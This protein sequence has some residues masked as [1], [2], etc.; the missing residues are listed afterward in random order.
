M[1]KKKKLKAKKPTQLH[2]SPNPNYG[3]SD[4][5]PPFRR[6]HEASKPPPSQ[7]CPAPPPL[8]NP[9][10][11]RQKVFV[12][13]DSNGK[14]NPSKVDHYLQELQKKHGSNTIFEVEFIDSYTLP[15]TYRM[16]QER[17]H[18]DAIVVIA[19]GT[20]DIRL[21]K[22]SPDHR[23][24]KQNPQ[25]WVR[26]II[27]HLKAQTSNHNIRLVASP[28]STLFDIK[29]FN[30]FNFHLCRSEGVVFAYTLA[31]KEHL[32]RDGYHIS[33]MFSNVVAQTTAAS[34]FNVNPTLAFSISKQ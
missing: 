33:F 17:D 12:Y 31:R 2:I 8:R 3:T 6:Q 20:N 13:Q 18:T 32:A 26:K 4:S 10:W 9:W 25:A 15:R 19:V 24:S 5:E 28:P 29:S 22:Q 14:R 27:S 11:K 1:I 34:I 21:R 23:Y 16:M 30:N 7:F